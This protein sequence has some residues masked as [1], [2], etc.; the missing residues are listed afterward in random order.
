[1][2]N[3]AELGIFLDQLYWGR[4]YGRDAVKLLVR[5]TFGKTSIN[6]IHLGTFKE[7]IRAQRSFAACGFRMVGVSGRYNPILDKYM[8]GIE[9]EI[10]R[11]DFISNAQQTNSLIIASRK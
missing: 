5:Y 4:R 11:Q 8:D 3:E 7:N 10:K 6:R 2:K 1:V 9:M